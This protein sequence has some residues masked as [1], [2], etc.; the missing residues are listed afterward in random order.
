MARKKRRS[1]TPLFLFLSALLLMALIF[2]GLN[3]L[4][5]TERYQYESSL[6]PTPSP[7]PR[8]VAVTMDPNLI[9]PTPAPTAMA[10]QNGSKGD[11]VSAIQ[12]RL[13]ELGYYQGE[14]DG[15]FGAASKAA[16]IWFQTQ[17]QLDADGIVGDKTYEL[18]FSASAGQAVATPSPAST[19]VLQGSVPLLVNR[20]HTL[21]ASFLP[22][23]LV[24][25]KDE[26]PAD[27]VT[28][29]GSDIQGVKTAVDAL[30]TMLSA[31]HEDGITV[32]QVSAGYRSYAY[33]KSLFDKKVKAFMDNGSDR[34]SAISSTR[35]T[36]ADPGSSE[37]HTG[38]A[39]DI[40]VPGTATFLG[41]KQCT[42][43][44]EHCWEYGFIIRYTDEKE[45][46]TGYTGEAWHIRYVGLEHSTLM[47][48]MNYCLEE[49]V[50]YLNGAQTQQ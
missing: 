44:H 19:D 45:K 15:Q 7:T 17:H 21:D 48:D 28:I 12:Q 40:T 49:Y 32:W 36:V 35:V 4:S 3:T 38:L 31:A 37:H 29:K 16:V 2:I 50:D 22:S 27:L 18:L 43:L 10:I 1:A 34:S 26:C 13:K 11:L 9:T 20:S 6:T 14:V 25:L 41:T 30:K 39:F 42:W 23:D 8:N 24:Y 47:R 33:Q 46:I 5:K